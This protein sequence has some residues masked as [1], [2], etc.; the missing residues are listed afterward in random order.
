[1]EKGF[2]TIRVPNERIDQN[3]DFVAKSVAMTAKGKYRRSKQKRKK[4]KIGVKSHF[5]K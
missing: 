2:I 1:M 3:T 4:T 5:R